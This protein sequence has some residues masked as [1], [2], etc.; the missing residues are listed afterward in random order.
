MKDIGSLLVLS[1]ASIAVLTFFWSLFQTVFLEK[2]MNTD[3]EEKM[4]TTVAVGALLVAVG[5]LVLWLS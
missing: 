5:L 2:P 3:Y 1:G 4:T